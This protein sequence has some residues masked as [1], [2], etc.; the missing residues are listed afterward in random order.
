MSPRRL[1]GTS[2]V[3]AAVA[4]TTLTTAVVSS[5]SADPAPDAPGTLVAAEPTTAF[6]APL[7]PLPGRAWSLLYRSTSAT[8]E[9]NIVS[10][11]LLVPP[12]EWIGDGERP[13]VSYAIGTH[14]LGDRCAPS[15]QL[16]AGTEQELNLMALALG[17]GWAVAVTDYE[18]LGTTPGTHTY[19]VALSEGHAVLYAVRAAVAVP[20]ADLSDDAPVGI[21]GYSQGGGAAAVAGEQA[22]GYAPELDVRGVAAG[23]VPARLVEVFEANVRNRIATGLIAAATTGFDAAYPDLRL[24][25]RLDTTGQ[26]LY[27]DVRDECVGQI[28]AKG[29]PFTFAQLGAVP[30]AGEAGERLEDNSAG[31]VAPA[32]PALVYH[33]GADELI[34]VAQGRGLRDDWCDLGVDVSYVELPAAGHIG[35]AELGGPVAVDSLAKRFAGAAAPSSC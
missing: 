12:G 22:A 13:I 28:V 21:W 14:G 33:A 4:A 20:G 26:A 10:G 35:G 16:A 15:A 11:T 8:G 7:V 25:D 5:A 23:G 30:L 3:A 1:L 27:D 24:R 31:D 32:F 18:G 6:A 34:P 29:L 19:T 17:R 2:L 9:A